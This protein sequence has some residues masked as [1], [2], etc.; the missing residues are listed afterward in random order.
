MRWRSMG[1]G[2]SSFFLELPK[3]KHRT[4][5]MSASHFQRA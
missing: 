2:V 3:R 5:S 4:A 1:V